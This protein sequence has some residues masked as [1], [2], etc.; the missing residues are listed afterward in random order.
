MPSGRYNYGPAAPAER[1]ANCGH[2]LEP[3]KAVC[4]NC[5]HLT[6]PPLPVLGTGDGAWP[7]RLR[8]LVGGVAAFGTLVFGVATGFTL[9]W[10]GLFAVCVVSAYVNGPSTR[11]GDFVF[12]AFILGLVALLLSWI[13]RLLFRVAKANLSGGGE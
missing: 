11:I 3:R 2:A 13:T 7:R 6:E 5:G 12:P 10:L 9:I 1:C 4:P 8:L